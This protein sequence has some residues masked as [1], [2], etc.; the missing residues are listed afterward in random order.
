ML[1]SCVF[2]EPNE[3]FDVLYRGVFLGCLQD[4]CTVG[5][6]ERRCY[7]GCYQNVGELDCGNTACLFADDSHGHEDSNPFNSS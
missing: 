2:S 7:H 4:V 3:R 5:L 1:S 6:D